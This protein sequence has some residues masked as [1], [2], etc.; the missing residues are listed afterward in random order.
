MDR[1]SRACLLIKYD[2]GEEM[3]YVASRSALFFFSF[4]KNKLTLTD[5]QVMAAGV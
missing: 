3:H 1:D 4:G 5:I 2:Q